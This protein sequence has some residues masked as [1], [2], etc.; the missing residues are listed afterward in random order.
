M[1]IV[2]GKLGNKNISAAKLG[3]VNPSS[4][5]RYMSGKNHSTHITRSSSVGVLNQVSFAMCMDNK[6]TENHI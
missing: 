6:N 5:F 3:S 1:T 2:S 4:Q